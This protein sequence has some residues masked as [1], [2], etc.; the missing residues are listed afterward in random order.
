MKV[1]LQIFCLNVFSLNSTI[2]KESSYPNLFL[3]YCFIKLQQQ[4]YWTVRNYCKAEQLAKFSVQIPL[5]CLDGLQDPITLQCAG[6]FLWANFPLYKLFHNQV[7]LKNCLQNIF[8]CLSINL[9]LR[10][11]VCYHEVQP[12]S[13]Y[14]IPLKFV[15]GQCDRIK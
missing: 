2:T 9:L 12:K 1:W 3:Q 15:I 14:K 5:I 11:P 8:I 7:F 13:S 10:K 6:C 4:S